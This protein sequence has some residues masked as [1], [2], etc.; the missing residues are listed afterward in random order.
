MRTNGKLRSRDERFLENMF[1]QVERTNFKTLE[2][3]VSYLI[4]SRKVSRLFF[5]KIVG[6]VVLLSFIV[7]SMLFEEV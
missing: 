5:S 7:V 1:E 2:D 6:K 3:A 4:I